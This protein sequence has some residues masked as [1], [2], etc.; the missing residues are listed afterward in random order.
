MRTLREVD[1]LAVFGQKHKKTGARKR[2]GRLVDVLFH[3]SELRVVGFAIELPDILMMVRRDDRFVALDRTHIDDDGVNVE[4]KAA[5]GGAAAKRLGIDWERTVVWLGMPVRTE[6]GASLGTVRD[7]MFDERDGHLKS[8]SLSE[9]VTADAAL[10]T[11]DFSASL[12]RG[13]E[14]DAVVVSDEARAVRT[15]GGAAAAA[16][17]GAA[18]AKVGAEQAAVAASKAAKVATAYGKSA[19][20]EASK[21]PNT[22]KALGFLKTMT[23]KVVDAARLPDDDE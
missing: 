6:S 10:G 23:D 15:D 9:G 20:K 12:V 4:G 8:I 7:V 3:P 14:V 13:F 18:R 1:R 5:W 19:L 22:R 2:I 17:K 11:R 21:H 16:G